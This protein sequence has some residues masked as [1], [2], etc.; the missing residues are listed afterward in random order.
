MVLEQ[1]KNEARPFGNEGRRVVLLITTPV[2]ESFQ[3]IAQATGF[4]A[5]RSTPVDWLSHENSALP[6]LASRLKFT[7]H[8]ALCVIG[9]EIWE[10]TSVSLLEK[11]R[12]ARFWD[13]P[14]DCTMMALSRSSRSN[15]S[16][17]PVCLNACRGWEDE[18]ICNIDSGEVIG[19]TDM[20]DKEITRDYAEL[21]RDWTYMPLFWNCHDL[22]I[23]LAYI[24][25]RPSMDGIRILKRLMI[26]LR[27][28]C[29]K[30]INW[31]STAGKVCLGG[32]GAGALGALASLPPL[33]IAG[34][35][36]FMVGWSVGFFGVFAVSAKEKQRHQF[37]IKLEEKF[38]QLRSL[39]NQAVLA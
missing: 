25:V 7:T 8:Y 19:R 22:A 23:R 16:A 28:A 24:I 5:P 29:Y 11:F 38:P 33:A 14:G 4:Q 10:S 20:S 27:Q 2:G 3:S 30:E 35:G 12:R 21:R 13:H 6:D 34:A 17:I 1:T 31:N 15:S 9:C 39:H 37:M 32:W 18:D 26:S 36:V